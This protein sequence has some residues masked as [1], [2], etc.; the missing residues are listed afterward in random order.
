MS[1][2]LIK[3]Q[4]ITNIIHTTFKTAKAEIKREGRISVKLRCDL[5]PP[6]VS[7]L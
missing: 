6:F 1:L 3:E 4:E 5:L 2:K 7:Y